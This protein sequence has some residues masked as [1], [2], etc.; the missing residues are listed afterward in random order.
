MYAGGNDR[1]P[2]S[3]ALWFDQ[4]FQ[5]TKAPVSVRNILSNCFAPYFLFSRRDPIKYFGAKSHH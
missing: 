3:G 4:R 5:S 2:P 1:Q